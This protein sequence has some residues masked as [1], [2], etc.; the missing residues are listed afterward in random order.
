VASPEFTKLLA[1][2]YIGEWNVDG[3]AARA[4]V[5][6]SREEFAALTEELGIDL[7]GTS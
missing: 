7:R 3:D 6:T 5:E 2:N 4:Q 1:D